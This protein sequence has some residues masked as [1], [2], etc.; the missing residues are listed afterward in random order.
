MLNEN[1]AIQLDQPGTKMPSN[2]VN[3]CEAINILFNSLKKYNEGGAWSNVYHAW[4]MYAN[5]V[6]IRIDRLTIPI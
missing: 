2:L 5:M 6:I 4:S 3:K 1:D